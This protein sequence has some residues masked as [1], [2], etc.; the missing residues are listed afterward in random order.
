MLIDGRRERNARFCYRE[1]SGAT[2]T[3]ISKRVVCRGGEKYISFPLEGTV[4]NVA[5]DGG[6][7]R[8]RMR[9]SVR[10]IRKTESL[11]ETL[12]LLF[13]YFVKG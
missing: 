9:A 2:E 5:G 7:M 8:C 6:G 10:I 12:R 1:K 11:I 13:S 4:S 3:L